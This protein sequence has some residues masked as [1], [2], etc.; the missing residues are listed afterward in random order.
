MITPRAR[1]DMRRMIHSE[2]IADGIL[3][4]NSPAPSNSDHAQ[5]TK[6]LS[7]V[8]YGNGHWSKDW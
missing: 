3:P 7:A 8:S 5:M 6:A 1:S 2:L 4:A